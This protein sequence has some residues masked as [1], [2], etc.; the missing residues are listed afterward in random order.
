MN[1]RLLTYV[2]AAFGVGLLAMPA[3]AVEYTFGSWPPA[4]DY[5]NRVALP[6]AFQ[7]IAK[8]L[9]NAVTWKLVPGGQLADPKGTFQAVQDGLMHGGLGIS[10]YV[11]NLIPSV[12]AVYSTVVFG[13]DTVGASA[14]ALETVTLNCPSCIEELKKINAIA[15]SAWNSSPYQ[16]ACTA[17]IRSLADLKGKRVRATG[18][19]AE[20]MTML[21]ATPVAATLVEAVGLLQ[22]GG[23][24]CQFGVHAWLKIFGYADFAKNV[25][26]YPLGLTGPAV[27]I[28]NRETILKLTP[29]QQKSFLRNMA[30]VSAGMS[31]GFFV[32]ENNEMLEDIKKTK[33]VQVMAPTDGAAWGEIAKKYDAAQRAKNIDDAR[34]FGVKDPEAIINAYEKNREKWG[35]IAKDA[36]DD[37]DKMAAAIQREVYDKVDL[38]KM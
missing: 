31:I 21:G 20:L 8:D 38:S 7:S 18:G 33:N 10:T 13:D 22:R 29:D 17:P 5:M 3:A 32:K 36:G 35:K 2:S 37:I 24:D 27:N 26:D 19:N 9:N 23:L 16:L 12:N 14:A 6:A 15:A 4:G 1:K 34:K 30:R 11:P 28:W 25:I